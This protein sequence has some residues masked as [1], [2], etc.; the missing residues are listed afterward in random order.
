MKRKKSF[1]AV[2][3]GI[4]VSHRMCSELQIKRVRVIICLRGMC[5][6]ERH[7]NAVVSSNDHSFKTK[8]KTTNG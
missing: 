3:T 7:I 4:Y 6:I 8:D 1:R 5:I 2:T